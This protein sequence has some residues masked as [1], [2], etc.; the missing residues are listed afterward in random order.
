MSGTVAGGAVETGPPGRPSDAGWKQLAN[1]VKGRVFLPGDAGHRVHSALFNKRYRHKRP[2]AVVCAADPADI[3]RSI[4]WARDH[5]V[6]IVARS[7]GH[8]FAGYSV[9]VGLVID[10]SRLSLVHAK[11]STGLVTVGGG[12][13]VGHLYDGVRPYE[14]AVPAGTNPVVG[15][16]GLALGGG[17]EFASRKLGLTSDALVETVIVTADCRLLTCNA[18]EN[19]ELF[20]ACRGGGGG[21]FGVNVSL[22]F[23]AQPVS[24]VTTFNFSWD[25]SNAIEVLDRWQRLLA[26]A[27]DDFSV[28]LGASTFGPGHAGAEQNRTVTTVGQLFG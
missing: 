6:P 17:S 1:S 24:D 27:P 26:Q 23:Q 8:S 10:L 3:Q 4:T 5:G 2:A 18:G 19:A 9:N 16:A 12:A 11:E 7:G 21:N 15:M 13:R 22:T 28:S 14:M 20:W 25:W